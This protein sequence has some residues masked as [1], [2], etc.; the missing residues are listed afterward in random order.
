MS[1][2]LMLNQTKR[3]NEVYLPIATEQIFIDDWLPIAREHS[4]EYIS[5]M[6]EGGYDISQENLIELIKEFEA[7]EKLFQNQK[8]YSAE[9]KDFFKRRLEQ[10][11]NTLREEVS[12]EGVKGWVG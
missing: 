6:Y 9:K 10:I 7:I 4:L 11:I 5:D 2:S 12:Y 3:N 8:N 1:L